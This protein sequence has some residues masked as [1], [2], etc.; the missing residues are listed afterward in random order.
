MRSKGNDRQGNLWTSVILTVGLVLVSGGPLGAAPRTAEIRVHGAVVQA[1][2]GTLWGWVQGAWLEAGAVGEEPG[3]PDT[4]S[5]GLDP[6]QDA[7]RSFRGDQ[8]A[9]IDPLGK[10]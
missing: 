3:N 10:N 2:L 7:T 8:G 4:R 1:W 5:G 6:V 9:S